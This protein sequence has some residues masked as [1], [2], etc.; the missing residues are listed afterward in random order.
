MNKEII[1]RYLNNRCTEEE[2]VIIQ[3]WIEQEGKQWYEAYFDMHFHDVQT[4]DS[5][6][7]ADAVFMQV[8]QI[9]RNNPQTEIVASFQQRKVVALGQH[10]YYKRWWVAAACMILLAGI[11][12]FS[13]QL[14]QESERSC[15]RT[16]LGTGR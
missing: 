7:A 2:R 6:A 16:C 13:L 14:S 3:R 4:P 12:W 1:E 10:R 15:E 5:T 11:A 8:L 9:I